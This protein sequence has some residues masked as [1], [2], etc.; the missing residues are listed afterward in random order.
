[1]RCLFSTTEPVAA[2]TKPRCPRANDVR[3]IHSG[4]MQVRW[5]RKL[6]TPTLAP[7]TYFMLWRRKFRVAPWAIAVI[8]IALSSAVGRLALSLSP[9]TFEAISGVGLGILVILGVPFSAP[10]LHFVASVVGV[11]VVSAPFLFRPWP[12][13]AGISSFIAVWSGFGCILFFGCDQSTNIIPQVVYLGLAPALWSYMIVAWFLRLPPELD[14]SWIIPLLSGPIFGLLSFFF[15]R[16]TFQ[17][18]MLYFGHFVYGPMLLISTAFLAYALLR[19]R[20]R[21]PTE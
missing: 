21:T 3:R 16:E 18:L 12:W 6:T 19:L 15:T 5:C 20:N 7:Q 1:M 11:A 17:M 13:I 14:R 2:A 4:S 8:S 10:F 9:Y